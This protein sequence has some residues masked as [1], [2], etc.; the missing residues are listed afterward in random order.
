ML[1][2]CHGSPLLPGEG[3]NC[4]VQA[5]D[6]LP[7]QPHPAWWVIRLLQWKAAPDTAPT[8]P[9]LCCSPVPP[10]PFPTALGTQYMTA[11]VLVGSE[12]MSAESLLLA[13]SESSFRFQP[14][15]SPRMAWLL[16]LLPQAEFAPWFPPPPCPGWASPLFLPGPLLFGS[17]F[18]SARGAI[19]DGWHASFVVGSFFPGTS[20]NHTIDPASNRG[21]I[22]SV[23][24]QPVSQPLPGGAPC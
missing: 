18:T 17:D 24:L 23:S 10:T 19:W 16:L 22:G 20:A 21:W 2:S 4:L 9:R 11:T 7:L 8:P 13:M 12:L 6:S 3:P 5:T 14:W 15:L 1:W